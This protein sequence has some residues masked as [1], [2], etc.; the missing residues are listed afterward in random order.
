MP[1]MD[2][3][4]SVR[5][6]NEVL[7]YRDDKELAL[8]KTKK[9]KLKK[10]KVKPVAKSPKIDLNIDDVSLG[11]WNHRIRKRVIPRIEGYEATVW[12][13]IVE[14]HYDSHEDA[15]NNKI[16]GWTVDGIAPGGE[17][18]EDLKWE[19]EH[20]LAA[21]SKPILEDSE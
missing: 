18:I 6:D 7:K 1:D 8:G 15:D 21:L 4:E 14:A 9:L 13:D 3:M 17:T 12:Y 16:S 10:P 5:V 11:C 2:E 20:M 19:L